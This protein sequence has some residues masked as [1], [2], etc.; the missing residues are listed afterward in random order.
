MTDAINQV[1]E[2]AKAHYEG[3]GRKSIEVEEWA[4]DDGKPTIIYSKPMTLR[5]KSKI[6]K[7]AR[8]DD[9]AI[10]V[11]AI[12]LKAENKEGEKLF[13]LEHKQA[14]LRSVD[15]DVVAR[16]GADIIGSETDMDEL[17]KN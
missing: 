9:L 3:Q 10:L 13:G 11:D 6:Y 12:I 4:D 7:G 15:A 14:L 8:K 17:E 2:R 5:E 1:L 16:I